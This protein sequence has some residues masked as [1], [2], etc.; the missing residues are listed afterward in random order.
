L[1][2]KQTGARVPAFPQAVWNRPVMHA[3]VGRRRS[4]VLGHDLARAL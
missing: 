1:M 2:L 4:R 3:R